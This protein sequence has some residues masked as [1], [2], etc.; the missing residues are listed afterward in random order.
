MRPTEDA[1]LRAIGSEGATT[2]QIAFFLS[3]SF[4]AAKRALNR[5]QARDVIEVRDGMWRK[6]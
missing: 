5:L 3:L 2:S 6:K 4:D 1:L